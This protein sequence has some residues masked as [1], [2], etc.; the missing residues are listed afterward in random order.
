M[1]PAF[2]YGGHPLA[3]VNGPFNAVTVE[4]DA[5]TE[6]TMSGPGRRRPADRLARCSA[7]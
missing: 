3:S 7:T 4:S 6:I 2:L 5:I 1:H